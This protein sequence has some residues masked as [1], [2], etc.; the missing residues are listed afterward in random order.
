M[1]FLKEDVKVDMSYQKYFLLLVTKYKHN[2][3]PSIHGIVMGFWFHK[4]LLQLVVSKN[5]LNPIVFPKKNEHK[6]FQKKLKKK[7][8]LNF[9]MYSLSFISNLYKNKQG[10]ERGRVL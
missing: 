9:S 5:H 3:C 10:C 8:T 4:L 6:D 1:F 7:I 2:Q